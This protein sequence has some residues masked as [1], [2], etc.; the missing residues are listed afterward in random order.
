MRVDS[1]SHSEIIT[2]PTCNKQA[3]VWVSPMFFSIP[4]V[5]EEGEQVY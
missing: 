1:V 4:V 2:C 3:Y 5:D